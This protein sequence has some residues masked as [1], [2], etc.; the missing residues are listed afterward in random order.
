MS[1][2]LSVLIV[3]C[4]FALALPAAASAAGQPIPGQY[5]VVL[6]D[7]AS[8]HQVAADHRRS[9]NADVLQTYDAALHGYAA[10]L[11]SSGLA[12]VK[13]DPRVSYVTQDVQGKPTFT[14]T[15][16]TGINRVDADLSP[17]AQYA[18]DGSGTVNG[19]VAVYDTGIQTNHPDLTV[20]GGVNCLDSTDQYNDHTYGDQYGHGTHVA[21]IIGAKDDANGVVGV[22]PGVRLWSV[23]VLNSQASGTT[24]S[25]L[26]GIN[27]V[28]ANGPRLG[29]KVVNASQ[30]LFGKPEDG[31]CGY[32][33]GD[34]LHQAICTSAAVGIVWVFAAGNSTL[35]ITNLPGGGYNEVLTVTA[36]AD[37][38]GQPNVGSTKTFTCGS[39][40][41]GSPNA[42]NNKKTTS[43][44]DDTDAYFSDWAST[45]A[46]Q[47]HTVAAPGVCI[48]S[49]FLNSSYGY[50]SGTS[51]SSPTAAG[52]VE[53]CI[54]SGQCT[55]SAPQ[56]IQKVVGDAAS[57]NTV[58]PSYG[59]IGDPLHNPISGRYYG[60]QIRAG[61]Y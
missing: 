59:F 46:Q 44:T 24:S 2:R 41:G 26:C 61:L 9:A 15:L 25:Q 35:P 17:T 57:Y 48:W 10:R 43:Y 32:T 5:I 38:N 42:A 1:K 55:G 54:L 19:D 7:G 31:N 22:A 11:S 14:Q 51:M 56:I 8:G 49:T 16:P 6:K 23:R 40:I 33:A 52:A 36:S 20:A 12:K 53:L 34:V 60:Y 45:A 27:W 4:A 13:A 47:A 39:A 21:G 18:G 28:T 30:G 50:L 3:I 29:I 58:N 37:S